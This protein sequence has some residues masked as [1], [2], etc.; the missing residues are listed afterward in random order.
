LAADSYGWLPGKES[1]LNSHYIFAESNIYNSSVDGS[2]ESVL[3]SAGW[4]FVTKKTTEGII[5]LTWELEDLKDTYFIVD[6]DIFVPAGRYNF[7]SA[8]L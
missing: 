8:L 1:L 4:S 2:L 7:F 5:Y 6:P 3:S